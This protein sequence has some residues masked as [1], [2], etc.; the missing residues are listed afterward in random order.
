MENVF[1]TFNKKHDNIIWFLGKNKI[2]LTV[3]YIILCIINR[4]VL[5]GV[6][7]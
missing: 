6:N 5:V 2:L 4:I 1:K 3:V 7:L